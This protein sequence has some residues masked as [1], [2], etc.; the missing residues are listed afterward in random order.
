MVKWFQN[1]LK[2]LQGKTEI[3]IVAEDFNELLRKRWLNLF[4]EISARIENIQT[5]KLHLMATYQSCIQKLENTH[6]GHIIICF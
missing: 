2:V 5:V 6:Q 3:F 4:L 1:N